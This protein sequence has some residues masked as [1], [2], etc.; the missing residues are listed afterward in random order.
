[1]KYLLQFTI[2]IGISFVAEI[3]SALLPG[4]IPGSIYGL[5]IMFLA[6]F[7][8]VIKVSQ[9]RETAVFFMEIMPVVFVPAGAAILFSGKLLEQIWFP[10][11]V[12]TI[13]S[14]IIVFGVSGT[15]TQIV[16]NITLKKA[17]KKILEKFEG[18]KC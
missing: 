1:M 16:Y 14:T 17:K 18:E 11:L 2:I 5:I 4:N 8:K 13:V 7:F 9:I 12:I 10:F 15:I 6:L 3:F